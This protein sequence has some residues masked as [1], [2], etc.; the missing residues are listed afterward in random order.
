MP[1]KR[2]FAWLAE[3]AGHG[4]GRGLGPAGTHRHSTVRR[5]HARALRVVGGCRSSPGT[6]LSLGARRPARRLHRVRQHRVA[7]DLCASAARQVWRRSTQAGPKA[8]LGAEARSTR[9]GSQPSAGL[10]AKLRP[11]KGASGRGQ[12]RQQRAFAK[13]RGSNTRCT[14]LPSMWPVA[15]ALV[16]HATWTGSRSDCFPRR[17]LMPTL[18]LEELACLNRTSRDRRKPTVGSEQARAGLSES[19]GTSVELRYSVR[20][21]SLVCGRSCANRRT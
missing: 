3:L 1:T 19:W 20:P 14:A 10:W 13:V 15:Q 21:C 9:Y 18:R 12:G 17:A 11:E 8:L 7:G 2:C 16:G 6:R 4:H 5:P